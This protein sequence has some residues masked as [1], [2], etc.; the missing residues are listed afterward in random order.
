MGKLIIQALDH[1]GTKGPF[2]LASL[3]GLP[4]GAPDRLRRDGILAVIKDRPD[5]AVVAEIVTDWSPDKGFS[6][7]QDLLQKFGPGKL[8]LIHGWGG[9][10]EVPG[11]RY[12]YK[13][14]GRTDVLFTSGELTKQTKEA[15]QNGWEYGVIIQDPTTLGRTIVNALPTMAPSFTTVPPDATVPL[16]T[17]TKANLSD[18][19]PF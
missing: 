11:A 15:I 3:R 9:A 17:C 5:I 18:F 6:G 8:N 10:V 1:S 4:D 14:A 2:S 19:T 16:P 12:T 13:T 7:T